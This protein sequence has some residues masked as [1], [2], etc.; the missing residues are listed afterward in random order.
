MRLAPLLL[1]VLAACEPM[2]PGSQ[3]AAGADPVLVAATSEPVVPARIVDGD[4]F[5]LGDETIRIANIDAAETPPRS[6]CASEAQQGERAKARL[7]EI[8]LLDWEVRP[9]LVREGRDRYGRTLARVTLLGEDVGDMMVRDGY[10]RRW[11][12]RRE[13]WCGT[14]R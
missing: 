7:G 4:T 9:T 2:D 10:A 11:T 5:V 3:F 8:L 12:G 1:L 14:G 6:R 13:P